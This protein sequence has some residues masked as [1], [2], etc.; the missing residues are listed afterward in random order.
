VPLGGK[1][2]KMIKIANGK[3]LKL[4][5]SC[6]LWRID[7]Y[8]RVAVQ[9]FLNKYHADKEFKAVVEG[10]SL[11]KTFAEAWRVFYEK[12]PML[13]AFAGGLD[14]TFPGTSTVESDVSLIG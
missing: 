8:L 10:T 5:S 13:D 14:A 9:L 1:N 4:Q 7:K 6:P 2:P 11:C 12:Y 3:E